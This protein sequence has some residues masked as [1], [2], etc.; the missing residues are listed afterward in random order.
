MPLYISLMK[1]TEQGI[2]DMKNF[3][4]RFEAST[5]YLKQLGAKMLAFYAT[6]GEYDYVAIAEGPTDEVAMQFLLTL[7][8]GGNVRTTTM[9][10]FTLDELTKIVEKLL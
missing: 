9:K 3:A 8:A 4:K 2:K 10:A 1:L 6:M 5:A 7:G